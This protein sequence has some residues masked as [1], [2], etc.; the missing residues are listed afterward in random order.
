MDG[1]VFDSGEG[2]ASRGKSRPVRSVTRNF[3]W[4]DLE[5]SQE[6]FLQQRGTN[7][8]ILLVFNIQHSVPTNMPIH[9]L[10]VLTSTYVYQNRPPLPSQPVVVNIG[11]KNQ[12]SLAQPFRGQPQLFHADV[13]NSCAG[14]YTR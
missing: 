14:T 6:G 12:R 7:P 13:L 2:Q 3:V 4:T 1:I 10:Y 8:T 5:S 9:H 11:Q